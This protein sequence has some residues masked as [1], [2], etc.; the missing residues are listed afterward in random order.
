MQAPSFSQLVDVVKLQ[1]LMDR[2]YAATG[3]PVGIIGIDG[4]IHVATGWQ[5]ICTKFHRAQPAT[6]SRCQQSDAYIREHLHLRDHVEYQCKNGL[7]DIAVPL[8]IADHHLATLFL[9]Q[10]FCEGETPDREFFRDQAREF[11]FDEEKYLA[12]L[13]SVPFFSKEKVH[14]IIDYYTFFVQFLMQTGFAT[15]KQMETEK[16]LRESK[17]Q[18]QIVFRASPDNI[19]VTRLSDHRIFDVNEKFVESFG[20]SRDELLGNTTQALKLWVNQDEQDRF[21]RLMRECGLCHE[22]EATFRTAAGAHIPLLISSQSITVEGDPLAISI[23]RD[24]TERKRQ[25]CKLRE[26]QSDLL[27]TS[28]KAGMAEIA[29]SVLH[30]VGNVLNSV[31]VSATLIVSRVRS[32]KMPG[33]LKAVQVMTSHASDLGEFLTVDERGKLLPGYLARLA[34]VLVAEQ[35]EIVDELKLLAKS[36]DHIKEIVATQQVFAGA[37]SIVEP[38]HIQEL[39]KEALRMHAE[40]L[41]RQQV[42]VVEEIAEMPAVPLDKTR[43]LQILVNLISNAE[44]AVSGATGTARCITLC[45]HLPNEECLRISVADDGEG[46]PAE[47][48]AR[49]FNHGFTTRKDG[50]GFGLH[51][52]ALAAKDM[53]GALTVQSDGPGKGA[54]FT[55]ELPIKT[56][57]GTSGQSESAGKSRT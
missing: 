14:R 49:I 26:A 37:S 40:S 5:D 2:F 4:V 18:M 19:L 34:E 30:N 57:E 35:Q 17:E 9:G 6:L 52:C 7:R 55:L 56:S 16:A 15:L 31:N 42:T 13:D 32:S 27:A 50:H 21:S 22:I 41:T 28:R 10:F 46:I 33:L 11:G 48:L 51:S 12:A 29:S 44:Q 45:A 23:C 25:E 53:G 54:T 24:I 36:V 38:V 39:V 1:E 47:N 3:I 20:H 8:V 43:V